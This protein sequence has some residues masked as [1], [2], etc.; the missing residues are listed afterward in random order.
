M[1]LAITLEGA[2]ILSYVTSYERT[3]NICTGVGA[4]TLM[5]DATYDM[6]TI[7]P[8]D[9]VVVTEDG[10]IKGRYYVLSVEKTFPESTVTLNCQDASILL[11]DYFIDESYNTLDTA[12]YCSYWITQFLTAAGATF[13][14]DTTDR[15]SLISNNTYMGMC[16]AY[17]AIVPLLAQCGW[18]MYFDSSNTCHINRIE[19]S[20]NNITLTDTQISSFHD[21]KN[22]KMLRNRA[23]VWGAGDYMTGGYVFAD[24]QIN[25]PWN[26]DSNDL[27]TTVMQNPNIPDNIVATQ[28]ANQIL[29][30]FSRLTD[31][32]TV[33]IVGYASVDIGY[34]AYINSHFGTRSGIVTS[35]ICRTS[36]SG[37]I[38]T[39][40]IGERC[41]RLVAYFNNNND[42]V[43]VGTSGAGIWYKPIQGPHTWADFST[44]LASYNVTDLNISYGAFASI[45]DKT[46]YTRFST[47]GMWTPYIIPNMTTISGV[48][49]SS[50]DLEAQACAINPTNNEIQFL[51]NTK[52]V[53]T[54]INGYPYLTD[55]CKSWLMKLNGIDRVL[56]SFPI[57]LSGVVISGYSTGD[58]NL[59]SYDLD[60]DG[61]YTYISVI[62][63]G[64]Y[65]PPAILGTVGSVDIEPGWYYAP[66]PTPVAS[67]LGNG[68][69]EVTEFHGGIDVW[70]RIWIRLIYDGPPGL[71]GFLHVDMTHLSG[72]PRVFNRDPSSPYYNLIVDGWDITGEPWFDPWTN[73]L[74]HHGVTLYN[75]NTINGQCLP[76]YT[77]IH[78]A[79]PVP[80]GVYG[81]PA[82]Q[83]HE[84][85]WLCIS[86]W[87]LEEIVGTAMWS[88]DK[89]Y[90]RPTGTHGEA[91]ITLV[92]NISGTSGVYGAIR[93]PNGLDYE[94]LTG[95]PNLAKVELSKGSPTVLYGGNQVYNNGF[96][97]YSVDGHTF[98]N[99]NLI[100]H[101]V[102]GNPALSGNAFVSDARN[103]DVV[104]GVEFIRY[105]GFVQHN[106]Y[107]G[108]SEVRLA[109][110]DLNPVWSSPTLSGVCIINGCLDHMET[111][112]QGYLN[113]P[114][115]FFSTISGNSYS[116]NTSE[117]Y[118]ID[119]DQNY[120]FMYNNNL[121]NSRITI[122]RTDD[123]T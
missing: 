30:E 115:M 64:I 31:E 89:I 70:A 110:Y 81:L 94:F 63:S 45:V 28:L 46:L 72:I 84:D 52:G 8:F 92:D 71:T 55:D 100:D 14:F 23:V 15:D 66:S 68:V 82:I 26:Y 85:R 42:N 78:F 80:G 87:P 32:T 120:M 58:D 61:R 121:P 7:D 35:L 17:D 12:Y 43:Y 75:W 3:H 56:T 116:N 86:F 95:T 107:N 22:D 114:Y 50:I 38:T 40:T 21:N 117:F 4:L 105:T 10:T 36:G 1:A 48:V 108:L 119:K 109:R 90:I 88:I 112:N 57:I 74:T 6:D 16:S 37:R 5:L 111:T 59:Y 53:Y 11:I 27:R 41:P 98:N 76:L 77:T 122:I 24:L 123:R 34:T 103:F 65:T 118:Q 79:T 19:N 29:N 106:Q 60:T 20:I 51:V 91:D 33:D 96:V 99:L 47:E 101:G 67:Y 83:A 54:E 73:T 102:L 2:S 62:A 18:Y 97:Y 25:T 13:V 69:F 93:T 104:S 9:I 44:G 39:I 113:T 49:V